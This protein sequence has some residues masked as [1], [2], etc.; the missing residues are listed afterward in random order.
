MVRSVSSPKNRYPSLFVAKLPSA[1]KPLLAFTLAQTVFRKPL[2]RDKYSRPW[3]LGRWMAG[4]WKAFV[5][6]G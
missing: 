1:A 6:I 2:W 5:T 4:M 3:A